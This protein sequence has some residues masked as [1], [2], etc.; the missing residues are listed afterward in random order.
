MIDKKLLFNSVS[1]ANFSIDMPKDTFKGMPIQP[2]KIIQ[3]PV[4]QP[5]KAGQR[6]ILTSSE[7]TI[8][9]DGSLNVGGPV[10]DGL[11][12][13]YVLFFDQID[14]PS[15]NMLEV[16]GESNDI[17]YLK[18]LGLLRRTRTILNGKFD[19]ASILLDSQKVTFEALDAQNPG[20]WSVAQSINSNAFRASDLTDD[21][22]ILVSLYDT[23]LIPNQVVHLDD[24][25]NFKESRDSELQSLRYHLDKTYQKIIASPDSDLAKLSEVGLL[26]ESL[27]NYNKSIN[28]T[29][30]KLLPSTLSANFT[31]SKA[32]TAGG[33]AFGL[34]MELPAIGLAAAAAGLDIK[35]TKGLRRERLQQTPFRYISSIGSELF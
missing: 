15:N 21:R 2:E 32:L 7:V 28:E 18:S 5:L 9:K 26:V 10:S 31:L 29:K 6:G 13:K 14:I 12:R 17:Q 34:G 22:G 8:N 24:V 33:I 16:G 23:I 20:A 1:K 4:I 11:L 3:P 25:I 30:M 35:A 27:A 19:G